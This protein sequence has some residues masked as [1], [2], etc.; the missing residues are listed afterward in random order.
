MTGLQS[1]RSPTRPPPAYVAARADAVRYA[2][3]QR[4]APALRHDMVANLQPM[5]MI[6]ELAEHQVAS[7]RADIATLLDSSA[8]MN[9]FG[10]AALACCLETSTWLERDSSATIPIAQAVGECSALLGRVFGFV[11]FRLINE[12][13]YEALQMP[14]DAVRHALTAALLAAVDTASGPS[15]VVLRTSHEGEAFVLTL[16]VVAQQDKRIAFTFDDNDRALTWDDVEAV[17]SAESIGFLKT[18]DGVSL[19]FPQ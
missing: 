18:P 17:A 10:K 15:D 2:V 9:R 16:S 14:R 1:Q 3:L 5:G 4:I 8:K 6:H 12:V 7:G 13:R 19:S 11:G